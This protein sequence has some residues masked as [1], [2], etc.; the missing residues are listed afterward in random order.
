MKKR[1]LILGVVAAPMLSLIVGVASA[2]SPYNNSA[3]SVPGSVQAEHYDYGGAGVAY[4]DTSSGNTGGQFRFDDVDIEHKAG[5]GYNVGWFSPGEWLEYSIDVNTAGTYD[6]SAVVA[7]SAGGGSLQ[8]EFTG[9]TYTSSSNIS[10]DN[11]GGWQNWITTPATAVTLNSGSHILRV[12]QQGGGFNLDAFTFSL[13]GSSDLPVAYP[14]YTGSYSGFTLKLDDRFDGFDSS[15]WARGDGAVGG[16]SM[17]RFQAQGVETSDGKLNLIVRKEYTPASWSNDHQSWKGAYG[18]S[19]GEIR[20][21]PSKR[22]K[23]GRIET[24][25]KAPQRA[26]ASG[27]IS[28]LF[29]YVNEGSPR[30]WEEIDIELEG[31]RP[32]KFQA[33]LIYGWDAPDWNTT[34]N[35]GA[36]EHK[37]NTGPVDD[38]RVFAIE[39]TPSAIKWFVDGALV[40][41]LDQDYIDCNPSCIWPQRY[42]TPIPDNLTELMM[43]FWIPNDY[44]QNN[45][46]GNKSNNV[47]PMTTQYDWIRIYQYDAHPLANW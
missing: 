7:S 32:D 29:T 18:Y 30:E 3:F 33:N 36:W 28:S 21:L 25:M 40:K 5:G 24:R 38:W 43:N 41:T 23:Y 31:G 45:F 4:S 11:T 27:Y 14:G 8:F 35:W 13:Q 22:I 26:S 37:I 44:I 47:Y 12:K 15:V 20:T 19:C 46:G 39:W 10:F 34:R 42:A 9:S 2:N 16:E 17:C 1:N 6:I